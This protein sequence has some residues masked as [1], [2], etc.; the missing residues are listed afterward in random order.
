VIAGID[1]A[2]VAAANRRGVNNAVVPMAGTSRAWRDGS[3]IE[4]ASVNIG[5]AAIPQHRV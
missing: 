4:T 1:I 2:A 5:V 3:T